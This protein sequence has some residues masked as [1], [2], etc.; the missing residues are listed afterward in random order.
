LNRDLALAPRGEG[1][2]VAAPGQ[3][4]ILR[5]AEEN[6]SG[7]DVHRLV[8]ILRERLKLILA[9]IAV[10]FLLSLAITM[11]TTPKYRAG[12][13]LQV[14]PPSVQ[15]IDQK[16]DSSS[17]SVDVWQFVATQVGLLQ[18]RELAEEVAQALG[19]ASNPGF[20][21]QSDDPAK[22]LEKA[23]KK[24]TENLEVAPQADGELIKFSYI[25]ESPQM[26][27]KV[28]NAYADAFINSSLQ[29]R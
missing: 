11:L 19:L 12:V 10:G 21:D 5:D 6:R 24:V 2:E 8:R 15:V 20:A 25:S 18:S 27:A 1:W 23:A 13:V 9:A 28:A 17:P 4:L 14:N 16:A 7:M 29:R 22:R 26:A 3:P